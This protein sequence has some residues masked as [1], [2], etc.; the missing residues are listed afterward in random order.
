MYD[1]VYEIV[2]WKSGKDVTDQEMINA[3]RSMV[4]DLKS[5]TGFLHQATY[6]DQTGNWVDI[7]YWKTEEDAIASNNSMANKQSFKE[8]IS[9]ILPDSVSIEILKPLQASGDVGFY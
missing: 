8:L 1:C 9:L 5:L 2:K 6:K 4:A 3:L 7:Y